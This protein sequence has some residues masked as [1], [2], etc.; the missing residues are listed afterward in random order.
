MVELMLVV[1]I[2][3]VLAAL[4]TFGVRRYVAAAKS[5]EATTNV[6]AMRDLRPGDAL[7]GVELL[8]LVARGRSGS[9][10]SARD[11]DGQVVALRVF[12][13]QGDASDAEA[14]RSGVAALNCL[15][16]E[17]ARGAVRIPRLVTVELDQLAEACI[18]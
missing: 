2:V 16:V 4:A 15:C 14:F 13:G 5:V 7:L 9:V 11:A 18:S 3:G 12:D 8:E 1:A 10:W 17:D 6:A